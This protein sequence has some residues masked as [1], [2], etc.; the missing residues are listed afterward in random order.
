M[1]RFY[2]LFYIVF[3]FVVGTNVSFATLPQAEVRLQINPTYGE[4]RVAKSLARLVGDNYDA[5]QIAIELLRA[6]DAATPHIKLFNRTGR[7]GAQHES[8]TAVEA[9][10]SHT[11]TIVVENIVTDKNTIKFQVKVIARSNDD[12]PYAAFGIFTTTRGD[13]V[14]TRGGVNW[15]RM[16]AGKKL[17][18]K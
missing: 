5:D 7:A 14:M 17:I 8:V 16:Y 2:F 13:D 11:S 10:S 12:K 15:F 18:I 1:Y 9:H 4:Q 6:L 3:V